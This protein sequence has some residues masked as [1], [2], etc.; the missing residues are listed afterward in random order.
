MP[1]HLP[2]H[3]YLG[4]GTTDFSKKPVNAADAVA[5][6]HD[7]AYASATSDNDVRS[8]DRTAISDFVATN[9]LPGYIGAA[10]LS[11]KYGVE[12]I[13]GVLYGNSSKNAEMSNKRHASSDPSTSKKGYYEIENSEEESSQI[14][15]DPYSLSPVS[16]PE[17]FDSYN[18]FNESSGM[19]SGAGGSAPGTDGGNVIG[20]G[21]NPA[22]TLKFTKKFQIYSGAYQFRNIDLEV[23]WG[24]QY[25]PAD[26]PV[27][28]VRHLTTPL[29]TL[30]P[31]M[32]PLFL[33][34]QEFE[35]LPPY[36][37]AKTC[38]IVVTPLGYR[39]PFETAATSAG[40]ANSQMI[41]QCAIGIGLNHKFEGVS[42]GY[43]SVAADYTRPTGLTPNIAL[44]NL[45]YGSVGGAQAYNAIGCNVGIPR[46]FNWYYSI[47][48]TG[49]FIPPGSQLD[50]STPNLLKTIKIMN[51]NDVRGKP[52]IDFTYSYKCA[53]IKM[54]QSSSVQ[55]FMFQ[56]SGSRSSTFKAWKPRNAI[57]ELQSSTNAIIDGV[58]N[59]AS[60]GNLFVPQ[61]DTILEKA[62]FLIIDP[63]VGKQSDVVPP[64]VHFGCMPI[65]SNPPLASP[66][67][68]A[69]GVIQWEIHTE[70]EVEFLTD[71][72]YP[73]NKGPW[74]IQYDPV[75]MRAIAAAGS[76]GMNCA[77]WKAFNRGRHVLSQASLP[78]TVAAEANIITATNVS[79]LP[80]DG[81]PAL[82]AVREHDEM[83]RDAE[84]TPEEL[85]NEK[86]MEISN[87]KN[88]DEDAT[89]EFCKSYRRSMR[90][91]AKY[92]KIHDKKKKST[93][94][95]SDS[96]RDGGIRI[97]DKPLPTKKTSM[98][99]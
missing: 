72:P 10:G 21:H 97:I 81:A 23:P 56:T 89:A 35:N 73:T 83:K 79:D 88:T 4:P 86:I 98:G 29:C 50:G 40:F 93:T 18:A 15:Q 80:N 7:L 70:L 45:L 46:H 43:T 55:T 14:E 63:K 61:Y 82:Q 12:S 52:I 24:A 6:T 59:N 91:A 85:S 71:S 60:I 49:Q 74:Q 37:F 36:C 95:T 78:Y 48:N 16:I 96:A 30:D 99:K 58:E 51:V 13:T 2:G 67:T 76:I 54:G 42:S 19:A 44:R 62:P 32:L 41:V 1:L 90:I 75:C 11:V 9:S 28:T 66:A 84:P 22:G 92:Q 5:R 34:E 39:L 3:N 64:Q 65:Q 26:P 77:T 68:F 27:S 17:S 53:P 38:K 20:A 47:F 94:D 87:I 25:S 69:P 31:N 57:S 8:A 33:S